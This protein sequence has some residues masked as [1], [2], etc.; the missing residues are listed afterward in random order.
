MEK[1]AFCAFARNRWDKHVFEQLLRNAFP[2]STLQGLSKAQILEKIYLYGM[3]EQY[4]EL[5]E[6][7]LALK[8]FDTAVSSTLLVKPKT[9]SGTAMLALGWLRSRLTNGKLYACP[10]HLLKV[11]GYAGY[12]ATASSE[13]PAAIQ[14]ILSILSCDQIV[15]STPSM[16]ELT[17]FK[18][19]NCYPSR[20]HVIHPYHLGPRPPRVIAVT[21]FS[22]AISDNGVAMLQPSPR[23]QYIDLDAWC[24]WRFCEFVQNLYGWGKVEFGSRL[25]IVPSLLRVLGESPVAFPPILKSDESLTLAESGNLLSNQRTPGY[26]MACTLLKNGSFSVSDKFMQVQPTH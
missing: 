1:P 11:V 4:A 25:A 12:D 16:K 21:I 18:V 2:K 3:E 19:V 26:D 5:K 17:F 24:R 20:R 13:D 15:T 10:S 8:H 7:Q 22:S 14:D 9:L 6:T 23:P